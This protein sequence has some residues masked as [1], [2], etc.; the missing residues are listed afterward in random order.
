MI[1]VHTYLEVS[2]DLEKGKEIQK[3]HAQIVKHIEA[4]KK[5]FEKKGKPTNPA[6]LA[7][8]AYM[9]LYT[10]YGFVK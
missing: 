2:E 5:H 10:G 6:N 4:T 8:H 3:K 7:G 9:A 1:T